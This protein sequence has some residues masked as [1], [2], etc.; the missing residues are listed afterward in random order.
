MLQI[1]DGKDGYLGRETA[2]QHAD[3]DGKADVVQGHVLQGKIPVSTL[4]RVKVE[5]F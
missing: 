5:V 3:E 4:L 1:R 2:E